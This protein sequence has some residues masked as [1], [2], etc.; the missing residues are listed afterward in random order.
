MPKVGQQGK[1]QK[2]KSGK[3]EKKEKELKKP[4]KVAQTREQLTKQAENIDANLDALKKLGLIGSGPVES[5]VDLTNMTKKQKKKLQMKK[6]R[7]KG[8]PK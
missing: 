7:A 8:T 5:S 2:Q 4:S 1:T 6:K 3:K